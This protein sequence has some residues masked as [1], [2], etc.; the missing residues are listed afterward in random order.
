MI[1][2]LPSLPR[3]DVVQPL[4]FERVLADIKT[5]LIRRYPQSAAVLDLESEPLVK[6]MQAFAWR[7]MLYRA[8]VNDA[9]RAHLLAFATGGDLD[10]LGSYYNLARMG[11]EDDGRYRTRLQLRIAAL[12]GQGTR[13]HYELKAMTASAA[14][15]AA[16]AW[17]PAVGQVQVLLWL[18]PEQAQDADQAEGVRQ[19][20]ERAL[21]ADDA[22]MLG[23]WLRVALARAR[24]IHITASLTRERSAPPGLLGEIEANMRRVFAASATLGQQVAR[25][26]IT[27]LLHVAGIAAVRYTDSDAPAEVTTLKHD[28][29]PQLGRITLTDAGVAP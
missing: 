3:P 2:H 25:S 5:D 29:Y 23:I 17:Q 10:H 19:A 9:A 24:P 20:V 7:E 13:E 21:N 8:R 22:R 27:T 16:R 14:V 6:L 28:E 11:G 4:D 26:Y 12:A 15:K 18:H 1:V